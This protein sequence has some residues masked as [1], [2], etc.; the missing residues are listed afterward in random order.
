MNDAELSRRFFLRCGVAGAVAGTAPHRRLRPIR[1]RRNSRRR[2]EKTRIVLHRRRTSSAT[3]RAASRC[4]TRC[5]DAKKKEVGLTRE[6]WKL[7]VISDPEN[8]ATLGK[9]LTKKDG[10]ALDFAALLK[11]GEKHA[12]RFAK[13]MTC[14]NIGCPLGMGIWEGVPLRDMLLADASRT[15]T[16][17]A[18]STTAITTTTRSRC[19][20]A[21]CR[22]AACSK[23]PSTCRR[24]SSATSSTASG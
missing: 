22:S 15:R 24:S 3:C 11:L 8:P 9:P 17:A 10:T 21:R 7:E 20:A 18:S 1:F 14:L 16:C 2:L 4:R 5:R 6:T 19:S 23:T 12:V 13:V